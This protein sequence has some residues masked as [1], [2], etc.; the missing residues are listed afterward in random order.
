M[1]K[2]KWMIRLTSRAGNRVRV[3]FPTKREANEFR[4]VRRIKATVRR[5]DY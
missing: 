3:Y 1:S 5:V 2:Q 4:V